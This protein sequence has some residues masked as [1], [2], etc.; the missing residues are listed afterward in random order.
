M[1]ASPEQFQHVTGSRS[2]H[3]RRDRALRCVDAVVLSLGILAVVILHGLM[4]TSGI[5]QIELGLFLILAGG[6]LGLSLS[7]R[8]R[9]SLVRKSFVRAHLAAF[10]LSG[11]WLAGM[12]VVL[13]FGPLLSEFTADGLTRF[14]AFVALSQLF[15]LLRGAADLLRLIRRATAGATDP[16]VVLVMS[17][18]ILITVGTG[19]LMLPRARAVDYVPPGEPQNPFVVAL[20]TSTSASCVTGLVVVPTGTYWSPFGQTVILGLFQVGGLGIMTFGAF[21]AVGAG[22]N[23]PVRESA[24]LRDMMESEQLGEVRRLVQAVLLFTLTSELIGA[25]LISGLFSHLPLSEQ[26][27]YSVFHSVSGFCNAGFSLTENSFVGMGHRWQVWGGMAGLIIIGGM[28]FSVLYNVSVWLRSRLGRL[29]FQP[30][31]H[32]PR[33][34]ARLSLTTKLALVTAIVLLLAGA[35]FYELL[36]AIGTPRDKPAGHRL[37]EAWFQSVTFRTAG[38]NTVDHGALQPATKLFAIMLM[39]VGASPGSTGGGVKTVCFGVA[40]LTLLS[41]LRG[42]NR[43]EI[44]G[45]TIPPDLVNRSLAIIGLGMLAVMLT[46]LLLMLFETNPEPQFLD[47]LFEATSAFGTVGVSAGVTASLSVPSKLVITVTMFAG[48]V[49]PLTLLIALAGR[50]RDARYD[51]PQER[52]ILG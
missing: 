25:V 28:G 7:L 18:A 51:Y 46:T 19:L 27:R 22:R 52:V 2:L 15:V 40:V 34:R 11:L 36:E 49:G 35:G 32:L 45:R 41:I 26:I 16:A 31:F 21:F 42:R 4:V 6:Y 30:L 1:S 29:E 9:W 33:E 24:N 48:R 20:F 12:V 3:P 38:F 5:V 47:Y 10:I 13:I 14:E 37:A 8:Y 50:R 39:F 23:V 17:F 44:A 43:V